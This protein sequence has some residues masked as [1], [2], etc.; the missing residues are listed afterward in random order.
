MFKNILIVSFVLISAG[1]IFFFFVIG[2]ERDLDKVVG[3]HQQPLI[4]LRDFVIYRYDD[5]EMKWTISANMANFLDPNVVQII[6]EV[7]GIRQTDDGGKESLDADSAI[8]YLRANSFS[9]FIQNARINKVEIDN[10]VKI[11]VKD[12]TITTDYAEYHDKAQMIQSEFPVNI[13]QQDNFF[14]GDSGFEYKIK[15]DALK[16]KGPLKG[17][18]K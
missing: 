5:D 11:V 17:M 16:V 7:N 9:E 18:I 10:D 12:Y 13:V 1:A 6:G 15:D 4:A 14:E 2:M 8:A 3:S